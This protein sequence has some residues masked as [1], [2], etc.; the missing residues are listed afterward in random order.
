MTTTRIAGAR[1]T[2]TAALIVA[3]LFSAVTPAFAGPFDTGS[4]GP[5]APGN[6]GPFEYEHQ[7]LARGNEGVEHGEWAGYD[8]VGSYGAWQLIPRN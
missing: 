1:A 6:L 2:A 8:C 7:C 4:A 3:G 5:A